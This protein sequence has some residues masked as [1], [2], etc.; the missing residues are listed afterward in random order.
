MTLSDDIDLLSRVSLFEGFP[1]EQLRM[2]AFGSKRQFFRGGEELYHQGDPSDGGY[3]VVSGQIDMV[4]QKKS[5]EMILASYLR[6]SLIGE[7]ALITRN[8]RVATA[9]ARNNVE[10]LHIPRELFNRM[11][12]EYPELAVDLHRKI[13]RS[14][15]FMLEDMGKVQKRMETIPDL[16]ATGFDNE[17]DPIS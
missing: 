8:S 3:V 1:L 14:V 16:A 4:M 13:S 15:G 2:L 17:D 12:S 9:I 6:S 10:V 11:L 7:M 5:R